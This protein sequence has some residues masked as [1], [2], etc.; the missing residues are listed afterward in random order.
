MGDYMIVIDAYR[1]GEDSGYTSNGIIEKDFNLMISKYI[2]NRLNELG[3]NTYLTR[4]TDTDL[5][6][7]Q[8]SELINNAFGTKNVIAI[9]NRLDNNDEEG[10][11]I[12]YSLKNSN[13]LANKLQKSFEERNIKVNKVYQKRDEND[14]S[15][16]YDEL[17]KN[18]N[19]ETIIINYGHINNQN[20]I[21]NLKNSYKEYAESVVK[22]IATQLGVSYLYDSSDEYLVKKGDSLWSIS[23]KYNISVDELKQY[24]NLKTNTLSINQILKIPSAES[25]SK[26]QITYTVAKGDSLWSVS[27]KFNTTVNDLKYINGLSSNILSIGQILIIPNKKTYTVKKGD[28]LW[29]IAKNNNTTVDILKSINNLSSNLLN[30]G[31]VLILP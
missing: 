22:T 8:R 21:S 18:T 23:K 9:S 29:L 3:I 6:I 12:I 15:K 17:L 5:N 25:N 27:Q 28:S 11:D 24:N 7:K 10:I 14:T 30:I 20:D 4:D 1:G 26:D 19:V 16:D 2:N 13:S 31:Q